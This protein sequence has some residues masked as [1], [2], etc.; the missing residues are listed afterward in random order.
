MITVPRMAKVLRQVFEQD[1]PQLAHSMGVVQ[2]KR[3]FNG[4]TLALVLV[5]GW[6][7]QP[8]AGESRAGPLCWNAGGEDQQARPR[9]ALDLSH[10]SLALPGAAASGAG[11]D[12]G[13]RG[14]HPAART[15]SWRVHRRWQQHPLTR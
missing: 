9:G 11:S 13:P 10:G 15:L 4:M 7:H 6:L 2:R 8:T 3:K 1:A 5:L 14:G 12:L